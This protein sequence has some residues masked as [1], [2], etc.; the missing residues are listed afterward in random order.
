M[1]NP[2]TT[3]TS[4]QPY[5]Q[6]VGYVDSTSD[7][8]GEYGNPLVLNKL[9]SLLVLMIN[10]LQQAGAQ[11][12]NRLNFLTAW[13]KAYTQQMNTIHVFTASNGD[14][15]ANI[16]TSIDYISVPPDGSTTD[17]TA[18]AS[19]DRSSLNQINTNYSQQMQGNNGVV[20]NDAKAL[21]SVVNQTND[22]VQSQSDMATSVL[23][24]LQ[25]ILTS[26]YQ[27]AS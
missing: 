16:G 8:A 4:L 5:L 12:A 18:T 10:A 14:G 17:A 20:S 15:T 11:Q 2:Q 19:N 13:Q 6:Q 27:S 25:T 21:Q 22:A 9:F 23:Q 24:Q 3:V 1:S 7:R 26:I